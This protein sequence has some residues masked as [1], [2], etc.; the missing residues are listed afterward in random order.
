MRTKAQVHA[1]SGHGNTIASLQVQ[2]T[3]PQVITGSHD[4]TIR[5]WDLVAGKTRVTLTHHKKSVRSVLVHP[6]LNMFASGAPDNL[7][8][9]MFPEGKFVQNLSGHNAIVNCQAMNTDNVLVSGGDN[10]TMFFW[11]WR[12]GYNFQRIQAAAQPGS[13][14]SESGVFAMQFDQS[15]SRLITAEADKTIKVYKEDDEATEETHP[16]DWRPDILRRRRY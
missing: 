8:Q 5:L 16:I 7:K 2:S 9:W 4:T 11:D 3:E 6:K 10:G 13:I 12:T 15:G 14:E 1:L